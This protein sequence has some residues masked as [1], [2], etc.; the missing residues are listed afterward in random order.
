MVAVGWTGT[1][2]AVCNK[3]ADLRDRNDNSVC[4]DCA[5][6]YPGV[7]APASTPSPDSTGTA[8]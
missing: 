7:T 1:V 5:P 2:K 3:P 6:H 4:V 8:P